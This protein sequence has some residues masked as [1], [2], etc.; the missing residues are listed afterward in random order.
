[1]ACQTLSFRELRDQHSDSPSTVDCSAQKQEHLSYDDDCHHLLQWPDPTARS[2]SRRESTTMCVGPV[3]LVPTVSKQHTKRNATSGKGGKLGVRE[4]RK[5]KMKQKQTPRGGRVGTTIT[6][7]VG[8]DGMETRSIC[9]DNHKSA[10]HS[11]GQSVARP[12][13]QELDGNERRQ[14]LPPGSAIPMGPSLCRP[15]PFQLRKTP[16]LGYVSVSWG[17]ERHD[18][19]RRQA[20]P[21]LVNDIEISRQ[22]GQMRHVDIVTN[23][24]HPDVDVRESTGGRGGGGRGA[25]CSE[26]T[27][28]MLG[29]G[30]INNMAG[31]TCGGRTSGYAYEPLSKG[32]DYRKVNGVAGDSVSEGNHSSTVQHDGL[33]DCYACSKCSRLC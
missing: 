17:D 21:N 15:Q 4:T 27:G 8:L 32:S 3:S 30:R 12:H 20:L 25:G 13:H 16:P 14:P 6:S 5:G 24:E 28:K 19:G 2:L 1:M 9:E 22:G 7:P 11:S 10:P 26:K 31:S 29:L 23:I 33:V 18:D